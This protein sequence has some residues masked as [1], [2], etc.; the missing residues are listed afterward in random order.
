MID[1]TLARG[2]RRVYLPHRCQAVVFVHGCA[3]V[4]GNALC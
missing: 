1:G 4:Y 2:R 3:G